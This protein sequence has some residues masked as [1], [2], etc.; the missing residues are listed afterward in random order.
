MKLKILFILILLIGGFASAKADES[1]HEQV[2]ADLIDDKEFI[3]ESDKYP[4]RKKTLERQELQYD[5]AFLVAALERAYSGRDYLSPA[6]YERLVNDVLTFDVTNSDGDIFCRYLADVFKRVPDNHL[7]MYGSCDDKIKKPIAPDVGKNIYTGQGY[8]SEIR[9]VGGKQIGLLSLGTIMPDKKDQ[10]WKGFKEAIARISKQTDALI[11]DLRGNHGGISVNIRWLAN[12]LYGGR[13]KMVD[14]TIIIR[15]SAAYFALQYNEPAFVILE[16]IK[17]HLPVQPYLIEEMKAELK[18]FKEFYK[19]PS[20]QVR[21][22]HKGSD[23]SFNPKT[24]YDKPIRI[25]IDGA[26]ASA[27]ESGYARFLLHPRVKTYGMNTKGVYHYG[28]NK[29]LVLPNSNIVVSI[30]TSFREFADGRFIEKIGYSPEIR[31]PSGH[32]ALEEALND[33]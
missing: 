29:P 5:V 16:A 30:P 17:R 22:V 23:A 32:D 2:I 7:F 15:K 3:Y 9:V 8:Y 14:E 1:S 31:V 26:C 4:V 12:Y 18:R 19:K 11:I 24:G 6:V 33:I 13:A 21:L 28:D 20:K 10:S 27:C 25:L